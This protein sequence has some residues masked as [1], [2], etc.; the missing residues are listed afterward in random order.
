MSCSV[1]PLRGVEPARILSRFIRISRYDIIRID[2]GC[3]IAALLRIGGDGIL[4][5]AFQAAIHQRNQELIQRAESN[6]FNGT[7]AVGR[8]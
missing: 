8:G 5:D 2:E 4:N 3:Q 6:L 1:K 7:V